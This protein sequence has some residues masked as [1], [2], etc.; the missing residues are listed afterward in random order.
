MIYSGS[1]GSSELSALPWT[2]R[3]TLGHSDVD[4]SDRWQV[5]GR[6]VIEIRQSEGTGA[7]FR[8]PRGE[9][10]LCP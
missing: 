10:G 4:I 1:L 2:S 9:S 3:G 7:S 6:T 8:R 5:N